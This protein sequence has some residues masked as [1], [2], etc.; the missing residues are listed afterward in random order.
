MSETWSKEHVLFL[1]QKPPTASGCWKMVNAKSYVTGIAEVLRMTK[2]LGLSLSSFCGSSY[3][4]HGFPQLHRG[5]AWGRRS[6][7]GCSVCKA[8]VRKGGCFQSSKGFISQNRQLGWVEMVL[9]WC[10]EGV[11]PLVATRN[12]VLSSKSNWRHVLEP[13][14]CSHEVFQDHSASRVCSDFWAQLWYPWAVAQHVA[15]PY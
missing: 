6:S 15:I 4:W 11:L 7:F 10:S 8:S 3:L 12:Q 9:W 14:R 13:I 5:F 2:G 1:I